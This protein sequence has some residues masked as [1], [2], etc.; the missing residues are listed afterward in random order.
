[1]PDTKSLKCRRCKCLPEL[2]QEEGRSEVIRCPRCGVFGERD[3]I[4]RTASEYFARSS[5]HS[6][7]HDFQ[8]RQVAATRRFKNVTYLPGKLPKLDPPAFTLQ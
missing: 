1:M 8:R 3:E 4:T 2:V 6:E 5:M 7:L